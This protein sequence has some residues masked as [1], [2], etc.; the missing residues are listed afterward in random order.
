M[1]RNAEI[2][3]KI[4]AEMAAAGFNWE[5]KQCLIK[6]KQLKTHYPRTTTSKKQKEIKQLKYFGLHFGKVDHNITL[7]NR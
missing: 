5:K 4:A 2:F 3:K 7:V 6:I 1:K